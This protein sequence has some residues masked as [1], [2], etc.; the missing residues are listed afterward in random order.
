MERHSPDVILLAA[1]LADMGG[2][3]CARS[4]KTDPATRDIPVILASSRQDG[5]DVS[6]C[7]EAGVD[8]FI[9]KPINAKELLVR[10]E[11]MSRFH[12]SKK[13]LVR[14][15]QV[16]GRQSWI[17]GLLLDFSRDLATAR[18]LDETLERTIR[19]VLQ[20]TSSSRAAILL[21]DS[22]RQVLRVVRTEGIDAAHGQAASVGVGES[23]S[24]RVFTTGKAQ[25]MNDPDRS[26]VRADE[27][28]LFDGTTWVSVPLDTGQRVVGVLNV[29]ACEK[30]D[31]YDAELFEYLDL[32]CSAAAASIHDHISRE[33]RDLA[34]D[35]IVFALAKL[36][37]YRDSDTGA[38]L[39]RVTSCCVLIA[40]Q[41]RTMDRYHSLITDQFLE[42]LKCAAPLHDI[43]KVAIPDSILNKPAT[44][45]STE[46]AIMETHAEIGASAIRSALR[47]TPEASFLDMATQIAHCHHEWFDGGGYPRGLA[48]DAIPLAARIVA[49]ADVY[50]AVTTKRVYKE[51]LSHEQTARLIY[52]NSGLQFD[53]D[54][55]RA[56]RA[57][58]LEIKR[59]SEELSDTAVRSA[60]IRTPFVI[61]VGAGI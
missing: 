9:S 4:L 12:I 24:G 17:L 57:R 1:K 48:A 41:L 26:A 27:A 28:A 20:L 13:E 23:V 19:V 52:D 31:H 32:I 51:T 25:V 49:I 10:V 55:V 7:R 18:D 35:S 46:R 38:H 47:H 61:S 16:R 53:P 56:F 45:T 59:L 29:G 11:S 44:L 58:E 21:P 2:L 43:G 33:S 40:E 14:S 6:T 3:E 34:R 50:D 22:T 5:L 54:I 15:N 42:D 36:A 60:E 30:N 37:E 8:E 39:E